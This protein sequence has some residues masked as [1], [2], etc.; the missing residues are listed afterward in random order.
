MRPHCSQLTI[1]FPLFAHTAVCV[2]TFMWQPV[3]TPCSTR[4][5]RSIAFANEQTLIPLHHF[6]IDSAGEIFAFDF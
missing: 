2:V 6:F 5:D 3:Q 4:D 1:S